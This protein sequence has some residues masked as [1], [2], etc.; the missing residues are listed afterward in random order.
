MSVTTLDFSQARFKHLN[1][2]FRLR[3]FLDGKETIT[4]EQAVSHRDCDL[5]KWLYS[6][7]IEKY[8]QYAEMHE[9]EKTHESLHS[10]IKRIVVLREK[11]EMDHAEAEFQKVEGISKTI[12]GFLDTLESKTIG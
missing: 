11:G 12:I 6:T 1:W 9:L 5:G 2:K 10:V 3:A 4:M 8:K 7:G